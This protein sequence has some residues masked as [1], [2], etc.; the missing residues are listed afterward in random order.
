MARGICVAFVPSSEC[1]GDQ[2]ASFDELALNGSNFTDL[3]WRL[4]VP[5]LREY[6]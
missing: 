4:D 1:S 5:T 3:L 6:P 2:Q